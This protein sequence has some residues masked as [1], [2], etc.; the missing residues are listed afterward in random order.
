MPQQQADLSVAQLENGGRQ[1]FLVRSLTMYSQALQ[2]R[3]DAG[4]VP[5]VSI[6]RN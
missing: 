3:A 4:G 6:A 5:T 2:P 1:M